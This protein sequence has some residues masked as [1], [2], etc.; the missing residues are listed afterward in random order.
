[1]GRLLGRIKRRADF[2]T[3]AAARRKWVGQGFVLQACPRSDENPETR[4][5]YTASRKVGGAVVRNRA[6]RRLRAL[7]DRVVTKAG[8]SGMDYVL[9][10]RRD[11]VRLPFSDMEQDLHRALQKV[12]TQRGK[13]GTA[14]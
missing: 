13:K 4:V 7:A 5:G 9:I 12:N 11:T 1:M 2:L 14:S 10:G 3:V 6:K 8:K